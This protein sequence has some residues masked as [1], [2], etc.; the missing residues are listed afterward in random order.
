MFN[1]FKVHKQHHQDLDDL[2]V[3]LM[4]EYQVLRDK[5]DALTEDVEY[6]ENYID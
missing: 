3:N 6:L 2:L 1:P 4:Y 5:V